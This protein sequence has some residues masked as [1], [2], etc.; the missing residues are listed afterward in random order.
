GAYDTRQI[1]GKPEPS[2][3][4]VIRWMEAY[5]AARLVGDEASTASL[6]ATTSDELR[7]SPAKGDEFLYHVVDAL[8]CDAAGDEER[9]RGHLASALK[10]TEPDGIRHMPVERVEELHVPMIAALGRLFEK[11]AQG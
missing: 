1:G 6:T 10:K 7:R 8:R 9:A 3:V 2:E 4:G 5:W 11:D